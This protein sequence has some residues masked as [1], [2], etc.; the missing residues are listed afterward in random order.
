MIKKLILVLSI[1][2][3]TVGASD[4]PQQS[5]YATFYDMEES[6]FSF[7]VM[8]PLE[9]I[10]EYA[11]CKAVWFAA[12]QEA[13]QVALS[14]P[15]YGNSLK[16]PNSLNLRVPDDWAVVDATA[17]MVSPKATVNPFVNIAEMAVVCRD[18]WDWYR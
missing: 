18:H 11:I 14:D 15:V 8:A 9:S 2:A 13:E 12:K 6:S 3:S 4:M 7:Q 5:M 10:R 1:L 16:E 17:F